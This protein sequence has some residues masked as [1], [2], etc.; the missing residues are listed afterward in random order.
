[1]DLTELHL[2]I[3]PSGSIPDRFVRFG[4]FAIPK[5]ALTSYRSLFS[6]STLP[7]VTSFISD[8]HNLDTFNEIEESSHTSYIFAFKHL[9]YIMNLPGSNSP[10]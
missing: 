9:F 1:M 3:L 2:Y 7:T 8:L 4:F 5:S 10:S 6:F